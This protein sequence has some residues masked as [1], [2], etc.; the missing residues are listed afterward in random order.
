MT[1]ASKQPTVVTPANWVS[2]P[3]QGDWTYD[4]YAALPDDGQ[5]YEIIDGVLLF[6]TPAPTPS[7]QQ[8]AGRIYR[9]FATH[10]EDTGL[11]RVFFAPLDIELAPKTVVQPDVFVLLK[12]GSAKITAKR[13]QGVPDLVVEV[14][15]PGTVGHDRSVKQKAYERAGVREYWFVDPLAHTIEMLVLEGK[16]YISL[17]V[18][19]EEKTLPSC[20]IPAL[21]EVP[22]E[23]FFV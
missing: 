18:F 22:A 14:S 16:Y 5:R 10:I 3:K 7:H 17:G 4:A 13:V 11:G 9:Y 21:E 8:V 1:T 23:K 12:T 15:S 19:S 2:G 20:I 6:M